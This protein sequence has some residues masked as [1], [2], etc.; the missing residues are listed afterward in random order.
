MPAV[1][2]RR[3]RGGGQEKQRSRPR[4]SPIVG[5]PRLAT[6]KLAAD[7]QGPAPIT[8]R[9]L[10]IFAAG[11]VL[12]AGAAIAGAT[13]LGG[14]LFDVNQAFANQADR[15]AMAL[16]LRAD[17]SVEGVNGARAAE[18][19]QLAL[20]EG[21]SSILSADPTQ[22]QARV[23]SLDWVAHAQVRRFW[24]NT[25]RIHVDSRAAVARWQEH[26]VISVIDAD[27]ER[28]MA[29]RA[30]DHPELPL[31][32]GVGA[33][34][35]AE[36]MLRALYELPNVRA[37]MAALVRVGER[38][39]NVELRNGG[40]VALPERDPVAALA[41]LEALHTNF[42]LLDR[43]VEMVDL[44]VGSRVVVREGQPLLGASTRLSRSA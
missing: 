40:T 26:G 28:L 6:I 42:G 17:V 15:S 18:V 33:S 13:W 16:G 22:V 43:P 2:S 34:R 36:P 41:R 35:A 9:G 39:W 5:M 32:V 7:W 12:F 27:G 30:A 19:A 20:P 21:R 23:E 37:R 14:S 25:V 1:R 4:P 8:A 38:R 44:R 29:E 11:T 24:P 10:G 3:P 31:V